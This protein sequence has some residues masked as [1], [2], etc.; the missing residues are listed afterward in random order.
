[1]IEFR[2]D[3]FQG[4]PD[5]P[6][7]PSETEDII[8]YTAFENGEKIGKCRCCVKGT[9]ARI[10]FL[11]FSVT[12]PYVGEG[13]IKSVL[14]CAAAKGAYIAKCGADVKGTC[15]LPFGFNF[16]E[17]EYTGEIPE[18]LMGKCCKFGNL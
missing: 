7:R 5:F 13:L 10:T 12:M 18:I 3:K 17:G 8:S 6:D 4:L 1:M 14:N 9:F 2:P 16:T 15:T 11:D